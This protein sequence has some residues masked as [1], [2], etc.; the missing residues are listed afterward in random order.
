MLTSYFVYILSRKSY[1]RNIY[2][3]EGL[4]LENH[5][6]TLQTEKGLLRKKIEKISIETWLN[7][8]KVVEVWGFFLMV[9]VNSSQ[10]FDILF[11]WLSIIQRI[12]NKKFL[13]SVYFLVLNPI[14]LT[15]FSMEK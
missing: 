8:I 10:M 14:G 5:Y 11:E 6:D 9:V 12:S 4:L 7:F 2:V 1:Y 3:M 13:F 15:Y